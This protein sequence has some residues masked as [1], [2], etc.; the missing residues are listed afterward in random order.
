MCNTSKQ[1]ISISP[2]MHPPI[3]HETYAL[4]YFD[5]II[6]ALYKFDVREKYSLIELHSSLWL[7]SPHLLEKRPI[8][9]L[10]SYCYLFQGFILNDLT[11]FLHI[12][13][14]YK[15]RFHQTVIHFRTYD[16]SQGFKITCIGSGITKF[17]VQM[18][19]LW[20]VHNKRS[21][22]LS[23]TYITR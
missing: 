16:R 10:L 6:F 1:S 18:K 7:I 20:Q 13:Y 15:Y 2:S 22:T 19:Y 14:F 12:C 5:R 21:N 23:C 17:L 3:Q 9:E 8:N 4:T 11:S